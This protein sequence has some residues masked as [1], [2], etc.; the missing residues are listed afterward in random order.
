MCPKED[1]RSVAPS[2]G[3]SWISGTL[4]FYIVEVADDLQMTSD[5]LL[6]GCSPSSS[7][8]FSISWRSW[9]TSADCPPKVPSSK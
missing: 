3:V 5:L 6:F 8:C 9:R 1:P 2:G 4:A 7:A